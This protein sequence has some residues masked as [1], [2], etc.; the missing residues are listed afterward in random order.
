M[1]SQ[2]CADQ[3]TDRYCTKVDT[4]K[5]ARLEQVKDK[6][7]ALAERKKATIESENPELKQSVM[8]NRS[9]S[10]CQTDGNICG[11]CSK[12]CRHVEVFT[13]VCCL[14]LAAIQRFLIVTVM[15]LP[16]L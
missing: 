5:S 8:S 15:P 11:A 1:S 9:S 12:Y 14:R 3:L 7:K 13:G 4:V 10:M 2:I 6:L 16:E